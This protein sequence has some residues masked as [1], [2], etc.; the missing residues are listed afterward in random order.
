MPP[1]HKSCGSHKQAAVLCKAPR[2]RQQGSERETAIGKGRAGR[3][4]RLV[5]AAGKVGRAGCRHGSQTEV[6]WA[7]A[8]GHGS[9]A[10]ARLD[11]LL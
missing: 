7:Y 10:A 8:L 3:A 2:C 9:E 11:T 4:V 1:E 5:R 6:R